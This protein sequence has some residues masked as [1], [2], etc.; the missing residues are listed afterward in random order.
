[1]KANII[2]SDLNPCGGGERL[3][4]VTMKALSEMGIDFDLTT[5]ALE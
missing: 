3:S 2:V 5:S 4:L 1:M